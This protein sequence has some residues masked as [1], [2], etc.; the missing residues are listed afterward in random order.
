MAKREKVALREDF[1][2][3]FECDYIFPYEEIEGNRKIIIYGAGKVGQQ[4]Y[5]FLKSQKRFE[6]SGWL[7]KNYFKLN[8]DMNI[9][10]PKT[11]IDKE[12]DIII[13]AVESISVFEE[14]KCEIEMLLGGKE[15]NIIGP[16]VKR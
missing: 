8:N 11:V 1:V 14:I 16:I 13:I 4:L 2:N 10:S 3:F 6:I 7:D 9:E 15:C 12:F 5:L